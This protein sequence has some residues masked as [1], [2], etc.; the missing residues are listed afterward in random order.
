M[1]QI[2]HYC[3]ILLLCGGIIASAWA[4]PSTAELDR[5]VA[6]GKS[7]HE[8][9]QYLFDTH[10]CKNCH[11]LGHDSKLGF[12]KKG[13]ER[14]QGFEGCISTLKAMS[15]I[16]KVPENQRSATQRSRAQRFEEFGCSTCHQLMPGKLGLTEVGAKLAHLHLGCVDV[17]KLLAGSPA[18]QR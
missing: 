12:T 8:I 18:S 15:I 1:K 7:Q 10:G 17:E 5:M 4:E 9:A 11:T 16:A 14:A 2:M 13:E 6:A 3:S